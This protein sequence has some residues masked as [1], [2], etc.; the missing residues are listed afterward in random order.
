MSM[1]SPRPSHL[2]FSARRAALL[3]CALLLAGCSSDGGGDWLAMFQA[4]RYQW[5]NRDAAA[6]INQAAAIP[7]ATLGVRVDGGREQILV[8]ATDAQGERMWTAG[9][10]VAIATRGGRIIRTAGFGADLSGYSNW[11]V[12][13]DWTRPHAH[14]WAA[15]F[16][17]LGLYSIPISCQTSA[18]VSDP[19]VILGKSFDTMRIDDNCQSDQLNWSFVNSYWVSAQT[20]R[21]WRSREQVHPKGPVL[22]I[23]LLRPPLTPG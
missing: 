18:A 23:E 22:E 4:A 8:L 13:A 10:A 9:T 17:D 5:E 15:D 2:R 21:V 19:I 7:Y 11:D 16:A 20:G 3:A 1:T 14:S 6:D 12:H